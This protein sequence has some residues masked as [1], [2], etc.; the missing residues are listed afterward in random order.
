[1]DSVLAPPFFW[2]PL[3]S[4]VFHCP[5]P[6]PS[7]VRAAVLLARFDAGGR[8][9]LLSVAWEALLGFRPGELHGRPLLALLPQERRAMAAA[10]LR[11]MLSPAEA[12]PIA[13]ELA[14]RDGTLLRMGCYRRFDPYDETLFIAGEPAGVTGAQYPAPSNRDRV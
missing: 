3:D 1:M 4:I 5:D 2:V 7:Y 13:L 9:R 11:R 12:D 10:A 8:F 14:R 6:Y